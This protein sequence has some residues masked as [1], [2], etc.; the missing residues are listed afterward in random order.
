M[1]GTIGEVAQAPRGSNS[2]SGFCKE[3][4]AVAQAVG[5]SPRPEFMVAA[6]W[7]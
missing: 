6:R 5:V 2:W 7:V 4:A 1:R 3:I